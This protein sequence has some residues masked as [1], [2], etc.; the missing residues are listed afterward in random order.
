MAAQKGKDLLLKAGDG[1]GGF[2]I[3]GDEDFLLSGHGLS[4]SN[5]GCRTLSIGQRW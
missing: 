2:D 3:D 1:A 5:C 4:R